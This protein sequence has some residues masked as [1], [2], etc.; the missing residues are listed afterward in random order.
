M[1]IDKKS[2]KSYVY[3]A[4]KKNKWQYHQDEVMGINNVG[5]SCIG[6]LSESNQ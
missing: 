6:T 1:P 2:N 3:L 4:S 5:I